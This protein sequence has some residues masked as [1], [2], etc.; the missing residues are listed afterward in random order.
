MFGTSCL[1]DLFLASED[2]DVLPSIGKLLL[3]YIASHPRRLYN[4]LIITEYTLPKLTKQILVI[5]SFIT[6]RL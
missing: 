3:D 5:Y 4:L 6:S 1:L 2:E